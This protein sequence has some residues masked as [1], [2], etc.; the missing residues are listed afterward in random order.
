MNRFLN[1]IKR[2]SGLFGFILLSLVLLAALA[3][4]IGLTIDPND[5]NFML[6]YAPPSSSHWLGTDMFGRDQFA[7]IIAGAQVSVSI[8]VLTVTIAV[9][10]GIII[11]ASC[12]FFGGWV[13]RLIM[14][15]IE[16]LMAFPSILLALTL[17]VIMGPNQYGVVLA[18]SLGYLPSVVRL[19]RGTVLSVKEREYVEASVA[20]GNS[21]I[22]TLFKHILPNSLA[23]LIVLSTTMF[24]WALLAES[25]L[26]F[27][28]LGVPPPAAT[29]GNML[30][31]AKSDLLTHPLLGIIPGAC[32]S[33]SL[34]GINFLGDA[35]R[36][37]L[38][39]RSRRQ[40]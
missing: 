22:Y 3:G 37:E 33:I 13:D 7:R 40:S 21:S 6:R 11:G 35:L 31:E 30:A 5:T 36:D 14:M 39:P 38:D 8:S 1:I 9:S 10:T 18:L 20:F 27:L 26:S 2:P 24:G 17:M 15:V 28:G 12:G 29:W 34:L 32:I 23:P 4:M 16:A 19:V 25:S